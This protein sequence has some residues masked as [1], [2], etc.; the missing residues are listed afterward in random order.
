MPSEVMTLDT[1]VKIFNLIKSK[2]SEAENLCEEVADLCGQAS[3]I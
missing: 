2:F 1:A 3:K